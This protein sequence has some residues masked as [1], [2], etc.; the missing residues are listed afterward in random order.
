VP[1]SSQPRQF[2][3]GAIR[4]LSQIKI[5]SRKRDEL[6]GNLLLLRHFGIDSAS[7]GR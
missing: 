6:C 7:T 4:A 5:Y 3:A 1:I 2:I